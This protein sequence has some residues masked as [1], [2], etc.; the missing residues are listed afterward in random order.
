MTS[1]PEPGLALTPAQEAIF[2]EQQVHH[3]TVHGGFLA[4]TMRGPVEPDEVEQACRRVCARHP[5]LR[6]VVVWGDRPSWA[7]S[8]A[9]LPPIAVA[10][11]PCSPGDE[12][13][14]AVRWY[15]AHGSTAAWDLEKEVAIRFTLLRHGGQR[16]TLV[17]G[18]HHIAFDG[19]SKFVFA[20][21]FNEALGRVRAGEAAPPPVLEV[22]RGVEPA[23]VDRTLN[24]YWRRAAISSLPELLLPD[25]APAVGH[26]VGSTGRYDVALTDIEQWRDL[27][28]GSKPTRFTCLLA[29]LVRQLHEYGN[30][31]FVLAVHT[32][33][34]S[35][36]SRGDIGL[37]VNTVP[38]H[39]RLPQRLS[40][41]QAVAR[42]VTLAEHVRRYRH[43]PFSWLGRALKTVDGP[44]AVGSALTWLSLSYTRPPVS[45]PAVPGIDLT[46]DFFAPNSS[47]SF[48]LVLQFRDEGDAL[49]GRLDYNDGVLS[50]AGADRFMRAFRTGSAPGRR[51]VGRPGVPPMV[52]SPGGSAPEPDRVL[53]L[54]CDGLAPATRQHDRAVAQL[55]AAREISPAVSWW[56]QV[57]TNDGG[58]DARAALGRHV[59]TLRSSTGAPGV[60][61]SD[62]HACGGLT[63][64]PAEGSVL[65]LPFAASGANAMIND[66]MAAGWAVLLAYDLG[67]DR[68]ATAYLRWGSQREHRLIVPT[69]HWRVQA[70]DGAPCPL[71][72]VGEITWRPVP[73]A[74]WRSTG[75]LGRRVSTDEL[76]VTGLVARRVRYAHRALH[77]EH[78]ERVALSSPAVSAAHAVVT[79]EW[80]DRSPGPHVIVNCEFHHPPEVRELRE[81]RRA[82]LAA[83]PRSWSPPKIVTV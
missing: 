1:T 8:T 77:L 41:R 32:D 35:P 26:R 79:D 44:V 7:P 82:T 63:T 72:V 78:V 68:R 81:I 54:T 14:S 70:P 25:A 53:S 38:V 59:R 9:D 13:E 80:G 36:A 31:N 75:F 42:A 34:S 19:R 74:D 73:D 66:L 71:F 48:D 33:T 39:V 11:L 6:S 67:P 49:Y 18:V 47:R 62:P 21:D 55:R 43:V 65:V 76:R 69:G 12:R 17:V 50:P 40:P 5:A 22:H 27:A 30:R 57:E 45:L 24:S 56:L 10:D 51:H 23:P 64:V 52:P 29:I 58:R 15:V 83:M 28:P 2:A 4:V 61:W 60:V 20:R 46:W 16:F 37:Q 3:Q